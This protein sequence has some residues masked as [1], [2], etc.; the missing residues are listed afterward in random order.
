MKSVAASS[1]LLIAGASAFSTAPR[2]YAG[3]S[4]TVVSQKSSLS[5]LPTNNNNNEDRSFY[6]FPSTESSSNFRLDAKPPKS[7]DEVTDG[8]A[9]LRQLLGVKGAAGTT[10]IWK[11]H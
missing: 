2:S 8:S 3:L 9:D 10:D 1:L 11:I 4:A 7:N 6:P 5:M